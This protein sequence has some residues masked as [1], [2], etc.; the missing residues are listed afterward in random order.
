MS[1]WKN[2]KN[3]L[4]EAYY[5]SH[6]SQISKSLLPSTVKMQTGEKINGPR[7]TSW[8]HSNF[9]G[10]HQEPGNPQADLLQEK[11][12][13]T[14]PSAPVFLSTLCILP[15]LARRSHPGSFP[16]PSAGIR[17]LLGVPMATGTSS[18][19]RPSA[20]LSTYWLVSHP[21]MGHAFCEGRHREDINAFTHSLTHSLQYAHNTPRNKCRLPVFTSPVPAIRGTQ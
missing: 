17:P 20:P 14:R 5:V 7:M 11:L 16:K 4:Q 6:L 15:G 19:R 1:T 13:P 9:S 18:T 10:G 3:T 2:S 8:K 21:T 12:H